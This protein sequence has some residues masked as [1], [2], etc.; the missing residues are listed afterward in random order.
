MNLYSCK[1]STQ[2][3]DNENVTEKETDKEKTV[4][5]STDPSTI[6]FMPHPPRDTLAAEYSQKQN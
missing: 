6:I 5:N 1:N 2:P 3:P 4:D